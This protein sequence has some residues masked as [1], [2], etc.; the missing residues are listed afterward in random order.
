MPTAA[1]FR[2]RTAMLRWTIEQAAAQAN[3][4][5]E[6]LPGPRRVRVAPLTTAMVV[7]YEAEG[8]ES[9]PEDMGPA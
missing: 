6:R 8:I 1:Q 9:R 5:Y 3:V 7:A 4:R 2:G